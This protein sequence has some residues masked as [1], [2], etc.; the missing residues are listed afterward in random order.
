MA[1]LAPLTVGTAG[2][3]DHGKTALVEA[4]TGTNT[5]RLDEERRR[6]ISIELGFAQL[7]L[8]DGRQ[9]SIVDVPGHERFLRTMVAGAS[10]IDLYLLVVAADDG[11]MPQT[12][13]HLAV[14][15]ALGID[16]GVLALSKSDLG[17]ARRADEVAAELRA[18]APNARPVITSATHGRGLTELRTA[19]A[20]AAS[21]ASR[22]RVPADPAWQE[23]AT[24]HIDR[25]FSLKGVGTVVTGTLR[26]SAVSRGQTVCL[27]PQRRQTRV[28]SIQVH[29]RAVERAEPRQRIALNLAG[30]HRTEVRRGD[31]VAALDAGRD[32]LR[33]SHRADVELMLEPEAASLDGDRVQVHHGTRESPGRV[34][35]LDPA[36]RFA[37]IR[38][39]SPIIARPG[40][41]VVLRSIARPDTLGGAEIVDPHPRRHGPGSR[42]TELE[43]IADGRPADLIAA[44]LATGARI[45]AD[46]DRWGGVPVIGSALHRHSQRDWRNGLEELMVDGSVVERDGYVVA[47]RRGEAESL[48]KAPEAQLSVDDHEALAILEA[49]GSKPRSQLAIADD[50]GRAVSE[51]EASVKRLCGAGLAVR[52]GRAVVYE[53]DEYRRLRER[54][55]TLIRDRGGS[56]SLG[57]A[58]TELSTSRKYAQAWL[59]H[60]DGSGATVRHGDRHHLRSHMGRQGSGGPAGL[61]SQ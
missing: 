23:P 6:G 2:H 57:E 24:V 47:P 17:D 8:P 18:L 46:P 45:P 14:L 15:R 49:D 25:V 58:R 10:G 56:I 12:R 32:D 26:G 1:D 48:E 44:G 43:L 37:Q 35:H 40:D 4:L 13:E 39:E 36:S 59:E 52:L 55:L 16:H 20:A 61:Q 9:L 22:A 5:D 38:I 33:A 53:A 34:V 30:V 21:E 19:L 41:R 54:L 50:L 27:L 3:I 7:P 42:G 60:L 31:V 29:N 51:V 11:V 28:R